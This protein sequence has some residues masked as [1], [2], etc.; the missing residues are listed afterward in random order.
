MRMA[1]NLIPSSRGGANEIYLETASIG[2]RHKPSHGG[3]AG[4]HRS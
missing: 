4:S 3:A 1:F 2:S